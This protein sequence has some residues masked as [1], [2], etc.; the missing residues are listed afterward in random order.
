M[1]E[2]RQGE[3]QGSNELPPVETSEERSELGQRTKTSRSGR[4]RMVNGEEVESR[5]WMAA[6]KEKAS[7]GEHRGRPTRKETVRCL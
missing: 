6:D 2:V 7:K 3:T 4:L 5:E 1:N